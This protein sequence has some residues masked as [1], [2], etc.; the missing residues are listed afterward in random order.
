MV[1]G[2][3]GLGDLGNDVLI[4]VILVNDYNKDINFV[5]FVGSIGDL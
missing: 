2:F 4:E 1:G 5:I 3:F